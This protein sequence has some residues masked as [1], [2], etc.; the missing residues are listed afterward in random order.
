MIRKHTLITGTGRAGT[1][2]LVQ[3][4][5][6]LGLDT[7]FSANNMPINNTARAGLEF[8]LLNEN[9]PYIVKHPSFIYEAEEVLN[10]DDIIIDHIFIPIRDLYSA[11]ESRRKVER[12]G[13][14]S[15]SLTDRILYR[16]NL[17]QLPGAL[18]RTR[19]KNKQ[20]DVLVNALY[21]ALLHVSE[22][23]IPVTLIQYPK[24]TKDSDYL[25]YKL[26]PIL[27]DIDKD[28]FKSVFEKTVRPDLVST[29]KKSR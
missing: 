18:T 15:I 2:F 28:T 27:K 4:L 29:F 12:D 17:K 7:G 13:L 8:S 14:K 20:E 5:T 19:S 9:S 22:K 10:K 3:L 6:N 26:K 21:A 24:L 25:F 11:A 1:T 16:L 23:D